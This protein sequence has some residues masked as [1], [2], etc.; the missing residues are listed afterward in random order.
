MALA[1]ALAVAVASA[2]V[3]A[4]FCCFHSSNARRADSFSFDRSTIALAVRRHFLLPDDQSGR[5]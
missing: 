3:A 4:C 2:A 5:P 1:L